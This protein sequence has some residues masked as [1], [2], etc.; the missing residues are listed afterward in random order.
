MAG[1]KACQ[2][3]IDVDRDDLGQG[4]L[5][6]ASQVPRH[7]YAA[8][9]QAGENVP[10]TQGQLGRRQKASQ[11]IVDMRIGAGLVKHDVTTSERSKVVRDVGEERGCLVRRRPVRAGSDMDDA[12]RT[13]RDRN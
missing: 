7:R 9:A 5:V 11:R 6:A 4:P 8:L 13:E 3:R 12:R 2:E 10:V 1:A